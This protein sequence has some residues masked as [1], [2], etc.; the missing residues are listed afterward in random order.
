[1]L[2][3]FSPPIKGSAIFV[4]KLSQSVNSNK[5]LSYNEYFYF[6]F[7]LELSGQQYWTKLQYTMQNVIA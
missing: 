1:M 5:F 6:F 3:S 7:I 4:S 2:V